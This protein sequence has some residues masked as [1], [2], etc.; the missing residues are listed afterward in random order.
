VRVA[1][2]VV[3][4][5]VPPHAAERHAHNSSSSQRSAVRLLQQHIKYSYTHLHDT[6][7]SFVSLQSLLHSPSHSYHWV[8]CPAQDATILRR[9]ELSLQHTMNAPMK[10]KRPAGRTFFTTVIALCILAALSFSTLPRQAA[11][12]SRQLAARSL[13][14]RRDEEVQHRNPTS[15][16]LG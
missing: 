12:D 14:D 9:C 3:V 7:H 10:R 15:Y 4:H 5:L 1:V 2:N 6:L 11:Q 16:L 13:L 8:T